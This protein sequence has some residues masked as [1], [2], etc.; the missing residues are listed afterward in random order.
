MSEHDLVRRPD[1]DEW[2]VTEVV[3]FMRDSE[4]EDLKTITAVVATDG[5]RI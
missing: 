1:G 2:S 3:G 5:A 4:R